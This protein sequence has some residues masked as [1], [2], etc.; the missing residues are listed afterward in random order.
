[1]LAGTG[2]VLLAGCDLDPRAEPETAPAPTSGVPSEVSVDADVEL[3]DRLRLSVLGAIGV[4]KSARSRYPRLRRPLADLLVMHEAHLA[5]LDEVG[6]VTDGL[7]T[8]AMISQ[9]GAAAALT[10]V[11]RLE[12]RQ[13]REL[14][15]MA[16]RA[17]S[18]PF[19][20]ML[21]SMS[22][23]VAAHLAALPETP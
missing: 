3:R 15:R 4:V 10:Q 13:Q 18:G 9:D 12:V 17:A 2:A 14:G 19:A 22:A 5:L 8:G 6:P 21:A 7:P 23:G 20:R 11:R 1:M 16:V